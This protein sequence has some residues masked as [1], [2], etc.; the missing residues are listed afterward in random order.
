MFIALIWPLNKSIEGQS[1]KN[2][3]ESLVAV[4]YPV[5]LKIQ[6]FVVYMGAIDKMR[7]FEISLWSQKVRL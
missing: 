1:A 5:P 4:F 3:N 7:D 6:V 2:V